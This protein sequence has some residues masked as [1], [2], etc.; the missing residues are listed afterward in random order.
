MN[1]ENSKKR[2]NKSA[3]MPKREL[4]KKLRRNKS[5]ISRELK[6]REKLQRLLPN[7]NVLKMSK[8][9]NMRNKRRKLSSLEKKR[10]NMR[11]LRKPF[12]K[13]WLRALTPMTLLSL[14]H[15]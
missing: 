10:E 1:K 3:L 5:Q 9:Y 4:R 8:S 11:K 14:S 12:K 13:R 2:L 15:S 7:R 6:L